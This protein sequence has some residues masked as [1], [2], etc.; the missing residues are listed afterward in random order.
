V[1]ALRERRWAPPAALLVAIVA[2][3]AVATRF[4]PFTW[5]MRVAVGVASFAVVA[6]AVQRG[7]LANP[8]RWDW[9]RSELPDAPRSHL[10]AGLAVW[11]VLLAV[12]TVFQLAVFTSNPRH[13]YPTLSSLANATFQADLV[14][15]AAF[16]A[17]LW[18]G[19]YLVKR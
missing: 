8:V 4:D 2:Y 16:S 1:T 11:V 13:T 15:I 18:V 14:R 3:A 17:W 9:V 6:L 19:W 12:L 5:P 7:W 10:L